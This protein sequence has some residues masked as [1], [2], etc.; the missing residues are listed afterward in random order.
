MTQLVEA[1]LALM[2][3]DGVPGAQ[4]AVRTRMPSCA[5][6]SG[7]CIA[8]ANVDSAAAVA[9]S[10]DLPHPRFLLQPRRDGQ[11]SGAGA[12]AH[13]PT[14]PGLQ[15]VACGLPPPATQTPKM[16]HS[17]K[18]AS[19]ACHGCCC[20]CLQPG[21]LGAAAQRAR[22]H[23]P[24]RLIRVPSRCEEA[25]RRAAVRRPCLE[26]DPCRPTSPQSNS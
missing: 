20:C 15:A 10:P 21:V 23:G 6:I 24:P 19:C 4:V 11:V 16:L 8:D 14:P 9:D 22:G 25:E 5:P 17:A 2:L 12:P 26:G 13:H 1:M 3:T 18:K 7:C